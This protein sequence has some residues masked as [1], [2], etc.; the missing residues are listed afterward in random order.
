MSTGV[1]SSTGVGPQEWKLW[2]HFLEKERGVGN[3]YSI[4]PI[5]GGVTFR[6]TYLGDSEFERLSNRQKFEI[7]EDNKNDYLLKWE[8]RPINE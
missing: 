5:D 3:K 1:V 6:A 2:N 4:K 7:D 8:T